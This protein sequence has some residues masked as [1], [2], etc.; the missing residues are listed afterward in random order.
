MFILSG[1]VELLFEALDIASKTWDTVMCIGIGAKVLVCLSI[2]LFV[3]L[4]VC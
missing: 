2:F 1:P 3:L 4:V